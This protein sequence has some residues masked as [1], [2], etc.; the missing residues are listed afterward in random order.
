MPRPGRARRPRGGPWR[1]AQPLCGLISCRDEPSL[2]RR[3]RGLSQ[4]RAG[5]EMRARLQRGI[6]DAVSMREADAGKVIKGCFSSVFARSFLQGVMFA[7]ITVLL[8]LDNFRHQEIERK[9][10]F[11]SVVF[12]MVLKF[13]SSFILSLSYNSTLPMHSPCSVHYSDK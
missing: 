5:T 11:I 2:R 4:G 7:F 1:S 10:T 6:R 8:A 13:P 12:F 3:R 9:K